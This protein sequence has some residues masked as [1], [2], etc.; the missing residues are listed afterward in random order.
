M[1]D[2][3]NKLKLDDEKLNGDR[4]DK[5]LFLVTNEYDSES[6]TDED[7]D[8]FII[9]VHNDSFLKYEFVK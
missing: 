6:N 7:I 4:C 8:D 2:N 5:N 9:L 1:L 3:E